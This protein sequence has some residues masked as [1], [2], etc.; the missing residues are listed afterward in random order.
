MA[1]K[2]LRNEASFG[3]IRFRGV[4]NILEIE[5]RLNVI[6]IGNSGIRTKANRE[7]WLSKNNNK[8]IDAAPN[9]NGAN[10]NKKEYGVIELDTVEGSNFYLS[11][12]L[13]GEVKKASY[14]ESSEEI[15]IAEG[16]KS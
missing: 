11:K 5:K 13:L 3:L 1:R 6:C 12:C 15:C 16:L 2:R 8:G 7:A 10:P 14:L 4:E 9:S